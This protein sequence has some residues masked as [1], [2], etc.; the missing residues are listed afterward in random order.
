MGV[1]GGM[2]IY[3]R[4]ITF[5]IIPVN[6]HVRSG[7]WGVGGSL[8]RFPFR[9]GNVTSRLV[10]DELD[11]DL[12]TTCLFVRLGLLLVLIATTLVRRIVVDKRVIPDRS[13]EGRWMPIAGH[14]VTWKVSA[15]SF[16]HGR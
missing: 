10:L 11:L 6:R 5:F 8:T 2:D 13:R 3:G 12:A 16:P 4:R 15:L 9:E 14:G 7:Q 1:H